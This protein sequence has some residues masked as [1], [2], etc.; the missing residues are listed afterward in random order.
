MSKRD[1]I[2]KTQNAYL[3]WHD[4][5]KAGV[6][7]NTTGATAAD[8]TM[9]TA[10][11]AALHAKMTAATA[12]DNASKAAHADLNTANRPLLT[13]GKPETRSYKAVFFL[14]KSEIGQQSDVAQATARP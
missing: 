8:M 2:P 5:L 4:T 3:K 13:A 12:A 1:A 11:N 14:G 6:T 9:L 7:A 10:D